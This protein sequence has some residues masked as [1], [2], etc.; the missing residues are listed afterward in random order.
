MDE[1]ETGESSYQKAKKIL[2]EC[3]YRSV[4]YQQM[5]S[6]AATKHD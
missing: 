4:K 2:F 6:Y 5:G 3:L 1:E